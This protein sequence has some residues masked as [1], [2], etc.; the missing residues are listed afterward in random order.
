MLLLL[1]VAWMIDRGR[2]WAAGVPLA[3]SILLIGVTPVWV[4]PV[5]FWACLVG[6]VGV[7]LNP[8]PGVLVRRPRGAGAPA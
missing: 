8:G 5:A 1:P 6:V 2:W 4:Y 3:T 7:A